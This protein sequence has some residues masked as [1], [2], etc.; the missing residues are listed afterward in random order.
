[1]VDTSALNELIAALRIETAQNSISPET[2]AGILY[3]ISALLAGATT[4]KEMEGFHNLQ[5]LVGALQQQSAL[6]LQ[7]STTLQQQANLQ[8]QDLT[9]LQDKVE[10]NEDDIAKL[11]PSLTS[12]QAKYQ[13][14]RDTLFI[15]AE[16]KDRFL[17]IRGAQ[18]LLDRNTVPYIFR[19]TRKVNRIRYR[20]AQGNT[21]KRKTKKR[22]GWHIMGGYDTIRLNERF[23]VSIDYRVHGKP[24]LEQSF[25]YHPMDFIKISTDKRG[26]KQVAYGKSMVSLW[27]DKLGKERVVKLRYGIAFAH[28]M[29]SNLVIQ[30]LHSNIAEFSVIYDPVDKSWSFGK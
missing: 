5:S 8:Q 30:N 25:S 16:V 21:K 14:L 24:K 22:K 27:D 11:Q 18:P 28:N 7:Q 13:G 6:L 1:M 3:R 23:E 2:I 29:Q 10:D 9:Q 17:T 12:L 19:R 20:D 4:D 26:K 15:A